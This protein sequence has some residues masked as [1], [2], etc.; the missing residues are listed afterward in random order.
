MDNENAEREV[1]SFCDIVEENLKRLKV[2]HE[3]DNLQLTQT[4]NQVAEQRKREIDEES[5]RDT[6]LSFPVRR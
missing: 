3:R 4:V 1:K 5:A 2:E 6:K